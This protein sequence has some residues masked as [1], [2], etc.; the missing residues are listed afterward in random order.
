MAKVKLAVVCGENR[1]KIIPFLKKYVVVNTLDEAVDVAFNRAECGDTVLLSPASTSFD[2]FKN[3][4]EKANCFKDAV[5]RLE[6][7]KD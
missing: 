3:Y 4:K 2:M 6:N 1:E 5:R 7:G